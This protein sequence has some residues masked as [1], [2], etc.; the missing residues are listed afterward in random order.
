VLSGFMTAAVPSATTNNQPTDKSINQPPTNPPTH[1]SILHSTSEL[2][3][4]SS[5]QASKQT[6]GQAGKQASKQ[7]SGQ[8]SQQASKQA[9]KQAGVCKADLCKCE[10][11]GSDEAQSKHQ[12]AIQNGLLRF[13]AVVLTARHQ[14]SHQARQGRGLPG[15]CPEEGLRP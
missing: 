12:V 4:Q 6:S 15:D 7:A 9:S 13:G 3:N 14:C 1:S 5:K 2:A 10:L 11:R 8:A